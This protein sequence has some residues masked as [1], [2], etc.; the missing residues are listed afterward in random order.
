MKYSIITVTHNGIEHTTKCLKS[1]F[2]FSQ[3][4]ELIVVDNGSTDGTRSMLQELVTRRDDVQIILNSENSTF[5]KANNQG[6][7]LATGDYIVFLN[8]DTTVCKDWLERMREHMDRV[9]VKNVGMIGPVSNNTNGRQCVGNQDAEAWHEQNKGR[10]SHTGIL[11]GWC[12]MAKRKVIEDIGGFDERFINSHEDNDLCLR[13]QLAGYKLMIAYDTY[14]HHTGQGT[15]TG[16]GFNAEKY[17]KNGH[18]MREAYYNK[19]YKPGPKK[20]VAVYRTNGGKWLEESLRQTSK[21]ADSILIHFC[22]APKEF[23]PNKFSIGEKIVERLVD[24]EWYIASLKSKFPKVVWTEFYD[25]IFQED[26]ERGR[27]LEMALE[28]HEKG[29][30]DWCISIDDDELYEDKFVDKVQRM[31]SPRNPEVLGYWCNW[32]TIWETRG[33]D[34]LWRSDSTFGKFTNYRFFKLMKGQEIITNHPEGHHCGSAPWLAPENLRWSNIRV[35]HMG[36][37]THEQRLKKYEFYQ[38]ND[39]FKSKAD[40]GYEDYRHLIHRNVTL[41]KWIPNNGI[42]LIMMVKN[43]EMMIR[44]CL[45]SIEQVVDEM[46]IVDTGSTDRTI[47]IINDYARY[48]TVKVKLVSYPWKDNYSLPRN[49][50]KSLATQPWILMLDADEKFDFQDV[51]T[52]LDMTETEAE[53]IIFHVL[54]YMKRT[55]MGE[56]PVYASTESVR[57]YRNIPELYYTGIIHETIDDAVCSLMA[58]REVKVARSPIPLHHYGYLKPKV[59]KKLEYYETLNNKQIAVTDGKDPRPYFNL[60]LHWMNDG[61]DKKALQ[62]LQ[63]ALTINPAF[64]HANQQMAAMNIKSAKEFLKRTIACIP[65][66]HPY[67][68][69][70]IEML[71]YLD[72]H[73]AGFIKTGD[74]QCQ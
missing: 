19:W 28:M 20:L 34:E 61:E 41:E 55:R 10:W 8:N 53:A 4:F 7:Q 12:I 43:E 44:N 72:Q 47:E 64:W 22:R 60:S 59:N 3:D 13:A 36:Y 26:Y 70:A 23:G 48:S 38:A 6:L 68:R 30:A 18:E 66:N 33:K 40:I 37:D 32:R 31:M 25:G 16:I 73:S 1:V 11:Y 63:Q 35:K 9:P 46:I 52:L 71:N 29:E 51:R 74:N 62:A 2:D 50:G 67:K 24:R 65:E 56:K 17:L 49:F 42:S 5:S 21:F 14:I 27:L 54:N 57:L 58:K 69:E 39:H 45:E 15:F